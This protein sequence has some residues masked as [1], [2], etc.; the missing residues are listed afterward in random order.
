[1]SPE[2][3]G[4]LLAILLLVPT[5]YVVH[6]YRLDSWAWTLIL[7]TLPVYYMLMGLLV[8]DTTAITLELLYGLPYILTALAVGTYFWAYRRFITTKE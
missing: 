7:A 2:L 6:T 4:I 1:M 5:F 3:I 8:A